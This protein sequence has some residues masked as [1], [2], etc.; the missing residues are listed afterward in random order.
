[1][2]SPMG[3]VAAGLVLVAAICFGI[4][5]MET[6]RV[7]PLLAS[8][9]FGSA[10]ASAGHQAQLTVPDWFGGVPSNGRVTTTFTLL[11]DHPADGQ[12]VFKTGTVHAGTAGRIVQKSGGGW[13]LTLSVFPWSD[14]ERMNGVLIPDLRAG[15]AYR[16]RFEIANQ[17]IL[18]AWLDGTQ[19]FT[20]ST[21][22]A[23]LQVLFNRATI[24]S[25]TGPAV[26]NFSESYAV[27]QSPSS[28]TLQLALRVI[29][30]MALAAALAIA[31]LAF[32][33]SPAVM[34]CLQGERSRSRRRLNLQGVA[35]GKL[36]VVAIGLA[37]VGI[38]LLD[39]A[40]PPENTLLRQ[41]G[42]QSISIPDVGSGVRTTEYLGGEPQVFRQASATDVLI[43]FDLRVTAIPRNR[44]T[45]FNV[46][47]TLSTNTG[48]NFSITQAG[49][50]VVSVPIKD[51]AGTEMTTLAN[52]VSG[53]QWV[54]VE[55][56]DLRDRSLQFRID[57]HL[58]YGY[59]YSLPEYTA[60]PATLVVGSSHTGIDVR[61]VSIF[62]RLYEDV[63][64][65]TTLLFS[66]VGQLLG[67]LL[68]AAGTALI[69]RALVRSAVP[70]IPVR[71]PLALV[72]FITAAVGISVN[73]A[74]DLLHVQSS[75]LSYYPRNSWLFSS[76]ARFSDFLQT[77]EI[78][79]SRS[80]YGVLAGSYPPVGYWIMA[81]FAWMNQY[82][83]AFAFLA[84]FVGFFVWWAR[85]SLADG[86]GPLG[87]LLIVV[88]CV[89]SY[90]V[91]FGIDRANVDLIVFIAIALGIRA[92]FQHRDRLSTSVLGLA[93][94][95]KVLPALYLVLYIARR[96]GR[97]F[98]ALASA[99]AVG[100]LASAIALLTF[101]GSFGSNIRGLRA[102][103]GA[104]DS[105]FS[106]AVSSTSFNSTLSGWA[107]GLAY[108][109]GG[110]SAA[111]RAADAIRHGLVFEET[112]GIIVLLWYVLRR[113]RSPWRSVTVV[114]VAILLLPQVSYAYE[115]L[116]LFIPLALFLQDA[117]V[118]DRSMRIALIFGLLLTPKSYFFL[119]N[120]QI[121]SSV[122]LNAP[123]LVAL[124]V[125]VIRDG[126]VEAR[127]DD[128]TAIR[129]P[130]T[131]EA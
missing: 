39:F 126:R 72:T 17:Q 40:T 51:L 100:L 22:T 112:F 26:S 44:H 58:V 37:V 121:D 33:S 36:L 35:R 76:A 34:A 66:R 99:V 97:R 55:M 80:P 14:S 69:A 42:Y 46:L 49:R 124:A 20:Y 104:I 73:I 2:A 123:L 93:A 43:S 53:G 29:A 70:K 107:Q 56:A 89:A 21:P 28:T 105:V 81:P 41:S 1:M 110:E 92:L 94:A 8:G 95:A 78:F 106:N 13:A 38:V 98:R 52:R 114:T 60:E 71:R 11:D 32:A 9:S 116:Y 19:L 62:V 4:S 90:P 15:V 85:R 113:E 25:R 108:A 50:L 109:I 115:L 79:K 74:V 54:R 96:N 65:R 48:S 12:L 61:N 6:P 111:Q 83:A 125:G 27:Y 30:G 75:T 3:R 16:V 88:V 91:T 120:S 10:S 31:L 122:L 7:G 18:T 63:P 84:I 130:V 102:G 64:T 45:T 24:G 127:H 119:G 101:T 47:S 59:T 67:F 103:L 68:L 77:F 23:S 117:T 57:G 87:Q 5:F 118:S 131:L 128:T 86:F 129:T 82:A